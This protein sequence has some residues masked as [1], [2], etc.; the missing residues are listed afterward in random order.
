VNTW[1]Q[2]MSDFAEGFVLFMLIGISLELG[3]IRRR[4]DVLIKKP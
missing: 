4:L 3:A 2:T 1:A